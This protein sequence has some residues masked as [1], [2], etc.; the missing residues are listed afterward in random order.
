[1]IDLVRKNGDK[2]D[3]KKLGAQLGCRAVAIS[4]LKGEGATEAAELAGRGPPGRAAQGSFPMCL[5]GS[6]EHAIAHIEESIQGR[7]DERFLRW[8]AVKTV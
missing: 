1:M 7:V 6:V 5:P 4:A 2:I 3:L 8:Y